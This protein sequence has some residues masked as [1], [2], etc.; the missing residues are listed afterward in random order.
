MNAGC[1][2][3]WRGV[4]VSVILAAACLL[5]N[6]RMAA[7]GATQARSEVSVTAAFLYNFAKFTEWPALPPGASIAMCVV[8]D[9]VMADAV[10]AT[11]RGERINGHP[12][13]VSQPQ[14]SAAW[15]RCQVLFISDAEIRRSTEA[16][17]RIRA[18]PVLTVS[19]ARAFAES[20]GII[21]L[22]VDSGK[23]RFA[24][25]VDAAERAGVRISSRLLGLAKIVRNTHAP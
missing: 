17:G 16:L 2:A 19:D 24:I 8:A 11:V 20:S 5:P 18:R 22:Y 23:M 1:R 6:D 13:G 21:E 10:A 4:G 7:A 12:L 14:D 25:N 3:R 9:A 15:E